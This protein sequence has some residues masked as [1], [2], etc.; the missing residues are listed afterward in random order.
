MDT[1]QHMEKS[2][3]GICRRK[4]LISYFSSKDNEENLLF[5]KNVT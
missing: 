2:K 4:T 5:S 1:E 3:G